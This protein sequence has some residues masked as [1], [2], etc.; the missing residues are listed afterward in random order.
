MKCVSMNAGIKDHDLQVVPVT[1]IGIK[2]LLI[3][4]SSQM[5]E[6]SF[7]HRVIR[8]VTSQR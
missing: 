2:R 8:R 7:P 4:F 5:T 6:D 3:V 1:S